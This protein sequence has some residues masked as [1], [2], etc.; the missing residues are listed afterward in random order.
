LLSVVADF[1]AM[2]FVVSGT[3]WE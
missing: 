1:V 3:G 2:L